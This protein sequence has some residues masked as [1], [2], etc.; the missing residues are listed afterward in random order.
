MSFFKRHIQK[1]S[2]KEYFISVWKTDNAGVSNSTSITLPLVSGG[3]YDFYVAW[4][5]GTRSH[6]TAYN[7]SEVTHD[8]GVAGTYTMRIWGTIVGIGFANGNDRL[9]FLNISRFGPLKSTNSYLGFDFRNCSNLTITATDFPDVV[10]ITQFISTFLN[11]FLLT[12]VPG[13]NRCVVAPNLYSLQGMFYA[14]VMFNQDITEFINKAK[15][16]VLTNMLVQ[17]LLF[18][19]NLSGWDISNLEDATGFLNLARLSTANFDATLISWNNQT[20]KDNVPID[21]GLSRYTP[22]GSAEAAKTALEGDGWTITCAG[23]VPTDGILTIGDSKT[24][25]DYTTWPTG[26]VASLET[27]HAGHTY[28][29]TINKGVGGSTVA[30]WA[31]TIDAVLATVPWVQKSVLINLGV[32]DIAAGLPSETAWKASYQYII[33]AIH[34]KYPSAKIYLT[35]P[36]MRGQAA[37]VALVAGY[38][39]D[40]ITANTG[41]CFAGDD[42]R[43]WYEGGDDGATM[44]IDG[45][46]P[47]VAG[48]AAKILQVVSFV[49][50]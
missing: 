45:V 29:D 6:I 8:Y 10:L 33:D 28:A 25:S 38:I 13:L 9:K 37:G 34:T 46:H 2:G 42:E 4:G 14:C 1:V 36:W 22:G 50:V 17:A 40:L 23:A 26:M 20:H 19:Q 15:P 49:T 48:N 41:V 18:D 44:T 11:N 35:T 5:D 12:S 21:F 7:Q 16:Y 3:T 47:S 43:G 24:N 30:I 27:A 31:G 39:S 32:N